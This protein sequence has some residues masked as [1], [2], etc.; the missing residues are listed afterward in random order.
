MKPIRSYRALFDK[1]VDAL[2]R[3]SLVAVGLFA[4]YLILIV[5]FVAS[6]HIPSSSMAPTL[7]AGDYVLIKKWQVGPRFFNPMDAAGHRPLT[8]HRWAGTRGIRRNDVL[9]F[10]YP[11]PERED[12]IGFKLSL[13]YIKRCIALPGDTLRIVDSRY[14]VSGHDGTLGNLAMQDSLQRTPDSVLMADIS[15]RYLRI[16]PNDTAFGW[17]RKRFGPLY[18]PRKGGVVGLTHR[19]YALYKNLIEWEQRKKLTEADGQYYLNDSL[20]RSYTFLKN[21]LFMGGDNSLASVDSR[22]WGPLPEE[23]VLGRASLIW[24]SVNMT[25]D[26]VRRARIM[27]QIE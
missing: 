22:Y 23:Y 11:Y 25:T 8:I 1:V 15:T 21:Y 5:F 4:L 9:V 26:K 3:L 7:I 2:F 12:S 10:N 19:T 6:A 24:N 27:K 18:I 14:R 17:T 20:V 16:Y 13:Y